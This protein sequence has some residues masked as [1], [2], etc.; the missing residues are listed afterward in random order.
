MLVE[1]FC[2]GG[3]LLILKFS[4]YYGSQVTHLRWKHPDA[5]LSPNG[6]HCDT[7]C[8]D[9]YVLPHDENELDQQQGSRYRFHTWIIVAQS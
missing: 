2:A 3:R 8:V 4:A 6:L 5:Y 7:L 9:I 1:I